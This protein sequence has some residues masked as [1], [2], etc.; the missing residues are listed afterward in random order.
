MK[1]LLDQGMAASK[2]FASKA[3]EKAQDWSEKGYKASKEFVSKA[4]ARAQ[5]L[6]ERGVLLLEIKQLESQAQKSLARLGTEVFQAYSDRQAK[7]IS[8]SEAPFTSII[9]E[10][11]SLRDSIE[12]REEDLKNRRKQGE[13]E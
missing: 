7:S 3:G 6:G 11:A 4:G 1:E 2:D 9:E 10:I 5:D 12:K 13:D 8:L